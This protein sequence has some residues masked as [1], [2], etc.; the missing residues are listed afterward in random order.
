[1]GAR[2]CTSLLLLLL[3]LFPHWSSCIPCRVTL[4]GVGESSLMG[5]QLGKP[6]LG[7]PGSF[8]SCGSE[9]SV[10]LP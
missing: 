9:W 4:A 2:N 10:L 6:H 7:F 5:E 1:M 3:L 8:A